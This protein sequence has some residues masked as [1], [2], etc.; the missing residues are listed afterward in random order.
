MCITAWLHTCAQFFYIELNLVPMQS[1][2]CIA[3]QYLSTCP[4][5][6]YFCLNPVG[7]IMHIQCKVYAAILGI[8][9]VLIITLS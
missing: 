1:N 5:A 7:N 8:V 6:L 4:G 2:V 3:E 9:M